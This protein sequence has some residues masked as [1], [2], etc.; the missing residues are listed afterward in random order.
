V[1]VFG[2]GPVSVFGTG[3]VLVRGSGAGAAGRGAGWP[4]L[5]GVIGGIT[6]VVA[7]GGAFARG[8]M[9]LGGAAPISAIA[10]IGSHERRAKS[11]LFVIA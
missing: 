5:I 9:A 3:T 10:T 6:D 11:P 8:A 4:T 2:A 7:M 1:S